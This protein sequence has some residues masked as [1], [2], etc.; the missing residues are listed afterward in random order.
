MVGT[1]NTGKVAGILGRLV[2]LL[3]CGFGYLCPSDNFITLA[4]ARTE[5]RLSRCTFLTLF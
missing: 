3:P 4:S 5:V 1:G 2:L